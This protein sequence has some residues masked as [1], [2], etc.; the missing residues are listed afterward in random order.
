MMGSGKSVVGRLLAERLD[1]PFYD[2][3][4]EIERSAGMTIERIFEE[5]GE[6]AFREEEARVLARFCRRE[7]GVLATGGGTVLRDVN[8]GLLARWG[9]TVYL[10]ADP[11]TLAARLGGVEEKGRPL[12]RGGGREELLRSILEERKAAY[13]GSDRIVDTDA[14][15][16]ETI[17]RQIEKYL[18]D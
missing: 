12:L 3:D 15:D 13:E 17:A 9:T 6:A 16:P 18:T 7:K 10:R 14:L 5:R 1:L 11:G 2:L 8:R 4:E